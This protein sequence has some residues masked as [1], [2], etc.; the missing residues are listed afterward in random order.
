MEILAF[1]AAPACRAT[2]M[3][4]EALVSHAKSYVYQETFKN[5]GNTWF[6]DMVARRR[7]VRT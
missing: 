5:I 4:V 3:P 1:L 6:A 2:H 7:N